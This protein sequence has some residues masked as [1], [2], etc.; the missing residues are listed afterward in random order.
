MV[1]ITEHCFLTIFLQ[2]DKRYH[3][4]LFEEPK[5]LI[6]YIMSHQHLITY[7]NL[8]KTKHPCTC[9]ILIR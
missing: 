8:T 1:V 2:K 6:D 9:L 7:A 3:K 4:K 5:I